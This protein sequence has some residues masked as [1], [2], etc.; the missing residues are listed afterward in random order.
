MDRNQFSTPAFRATREA[1]GLRIRVPVQSNR[2]GTLLNFVWLMIWAAAEAAILLFILGG[3]GSPGLASSVSLPIAG[4]L[5]AA[6]TIA[7]GVVLWRWLWC[8][9]GGETF[10]VTRDALSARRGIWGIGRSRTF[11]FKKIRSVRAARLRYRVLT[12]SWGRMFIGHAGSEIV[13]DWDGRDYFYGNGLEET[14]ARELVDLLEAEMKSRSPTELLPRMHSG[15]MA[16]T[17]MYR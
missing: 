2:F 8:V 16:R 4:L 15:L 6:F 7:G 13:I 3:L 9:G 10:V 12:P 1:Q 11:A 14:E 17:G 5:L